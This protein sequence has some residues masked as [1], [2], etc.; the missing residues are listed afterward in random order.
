MSEFNVK[1][2]DFAV[3]F[4]PGNYTSIANL[5]ELTP[6]TQTI[7]S[8]EVVYLGDTHMR[9]IPT[10]IDSGEVVIKVGY[11]PDN[12]THNGL[13]TMFAEELVVDKIKS[14]M[15]SYPDPTP[16]SYTFNA[17]VSSYALEAGDAKAQAILTVNL[18]I[19][20]EIT[21]A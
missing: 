4:S 11:D 17:F 13:L 10:I 16:S 5:I 20:G 21:K 14:C 9:K 2:M 12:S 19:T 7:D 6:P 18:T 8:Y 3:A 15:V 1:D